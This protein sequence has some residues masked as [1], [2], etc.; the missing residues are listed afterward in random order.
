MRAHAQKPVDWPAREAFR[1]STA[2]VVVVVVVV[3]G[4]GFRV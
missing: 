4:L 1:S 3:R 2:S